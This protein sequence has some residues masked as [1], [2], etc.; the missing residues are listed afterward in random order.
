MLFYFLYSLEEFTE[1]REIT[2]IYRLKELL[3]MPKA[4]S[5]ETKETSNADESIRKLEE[6]IRGKFFETEKRL[7]S[8]ESTKPESIEERI[9]EVEDLQM[10][11]QIE[12]MKLKERPAA[13][14]AVQT[15]LPLDIERKINDLLHR[16]DAIESQKL[17]EKSADY[18]ISKIV[19]EKKDLENEFDRLRSVKKDFEAILKEKEEISKRISDSELNL[20]KVDT[21]YSKMKTMDEK[22]SAE[23]DK[24]YAMMKNIGERVNDSIEKAGAVRKTVE[25]RIQI[26][27]D[28]FKLRSDRMEAL[29]DSLNA[30]LAMVDDKIRELDSFRK[31]VGD[32]NVFKAGMEEEAIQRIALEKGL[33]DLNRRIDD[34]EEGMN[35]FDIKKQ[36]EDEY[37]TMASLEKKMH[38]F[39][40]RFES[41]D[42]KTAAVA[43]SINAVMDSK[44]R[45]IEAKIKEV[46]EIKQIRDIYAKMDMFESKFESEAEFLDYTKSINNLREK[47]TFLEKTLK[48][49]EM[50]DYEKL[51]KEFETLKRSLRLA[52]GKDHAKISARINQI[53]A[54]MKKKEDYIKLEAELETLRRGLRITEGKEHAK[55]NQRISEI[56]AILR[57]AESTDYAK[58]EAELAALKRSLQTA[59]GEDHAKISARINQ[60][61][62][63]MKKKEDYTRLEAELETLKRSLRLADGKDHAKIS[64]RIAEIEAAL[65]TTES[66]DFAMLQSRL[67][68]LEKGLMDS[69]KIDHAKITKEISEIEKTL[70]AAENKVLSELRSEIEALKAMQGDIKKRVEEEILGK[71]GILDEARQ[72]FQ[73]EV[74]E[75]I[76]YFSSKIDELA[77]KMQLEKEQISKSLNM[78]ELMKIRNDIL[79]QKRA[80]HDIERNLEISAARFFTENLEEFAKELDKKIPQVVTRDEFAKEIRLFDTRLKRIHAPDTS[81]IE[82]R[83]VLLERKI[84]EIYAM[85]RNFS[86][87]QPII[88]E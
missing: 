11:S 19:R 37:V 17:T 30:K 67:S 52:E 3:D 75:K 70:K 53:E 41:L 61:E 9:K 27:E 49:T 12:I 71:E 78:D 13:V 57:K 42:A 66:H 7:V 32:V 80:I 82:Q 5:K 50:E 73:A 6:K 72:K 43:S 88:V 29:R 74:E 34:L 20:E 76:S 55:I 36:L 45:A 81:G 54:E 24:I 68:G 46:P 40:K 28:R 79:T 33:Q 44:I 85:T 35:A 63:E 47:I 65:K 8:L 86:M 1:P 23:V 77:M 56:E 31:I 26:A 51:E 60:I 87:Q 69:G 15:A 48:T 21:L 2:Y 62:A 25:S 16:M 64:S 18:F 58:L 59:E 39:S 10:L 14:Q 38:D 4:V 83:L 22:I 84:S